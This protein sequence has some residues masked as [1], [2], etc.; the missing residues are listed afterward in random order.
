MPGY[1]WDIP[2]INKTLFITFDD[3]PTPGVTD[4][5][6]E[7]L[8]KYNAKATFFCIGKNVTKHPELYHRIIHEGH[9][10]GNHTHGHIKGWKTSVSDYI[11]DIE[12]AS[13][14]IDSK[15]FRPPYGE[16]TIPKGRQLKKLGYKIIMWDVLAIDWKPQISPEKSVSNVIKNARN[17]SIIVFHDSIKA[18]R[19]MK[20][21][22]SETLAYFH[23]SGY[24]FK[25]IK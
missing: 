9:A 5:V 15:L 20:H 4:W 1:T 22:L 16:I 12:K 11:E 14:I 21:A 10:V 2:S 23:N 6:L 8:Q 17:G 3:G 25:S 18:S 19:N 24:T 13:E 7:E